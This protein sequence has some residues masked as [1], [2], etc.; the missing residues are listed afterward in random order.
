LLSL[1]GEL[2]FS[3]ESTAVGT[4]YAADSNPLLNYLPNITRIDLH[5][6]S[7]LSVQSL[8]VISNGVLLFPASNISYI[9]VSNSGVGNTIFD[10]QQCPKLETFKSTGTNAGIKLASGNIVS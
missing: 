3:I 5:G 10:M 9:D 7:N 2:D 1:V 4:I 8:G 6:C